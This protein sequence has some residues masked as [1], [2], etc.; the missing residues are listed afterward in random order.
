MLFSRNPPPSPPLSWRPTD[1]YQI[2]PSRPRSIL[3]IMNPADPDRTPQWEVVSEEHGI[4]ATGQYKGTTDLQLE[5]IGVYYSETGNNRYVPRAVLVDLEPGTMDVS[6][7]DARRRCE[8]EC[9]GV[10]K[11]TV[12]CASQ[13]IRSGPLGGVFRAWKRLRA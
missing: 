11:L 3:R 5:R 1:R 8:A 12:V 2:R 10:E 6:F 7:G 13:V 9:T 4:D